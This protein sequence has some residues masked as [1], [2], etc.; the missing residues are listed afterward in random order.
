MM[1]VAGKLLSSDPVI[2]DPDYPP[3]DFTDW[4]TRHDITRK[5]GYW[6]SDRRDPAPLEWP[7]WKEERESDNWRWSVWR[8]D[9]E[10]VL[11]TQDGR[12]NLWGYWTYVSG[13]RKETV[14]INSALV[15]PNRSVALLRALQSASN[16]YD[17]RIPDAGDE[18]EID[19]DGFHLKGW[20]FRQDSCVS[21]D[22]RDLWAGGI[23]YPPIKPDTFV[24]ELMN[25]HPDREYRTWLWHH[26]EREE[27]ALW[28]QTWGND[29]G[30][31]RG[32]EE[33]SGHRLQASFNFLWEFL[34]EVKKDMIVEVEIDRDS[35]STRYHKKQEGFIEYTPKST[36]LFLVKAGGDILA[37]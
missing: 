26:D 35:S 2:I 36:R 30:E 16:P 18:L 21:I 6:I 5:N 14:S 29:N 28:A 4:M 10:R 27:E 24:V 20:V 33:E 25:L 1:L 11:V 17:Y 9:F 31:D 3:D 34:K 32:T 7:H 8:D 23:M 12:I 22:K 37:I 15:S 13:Y 19:K